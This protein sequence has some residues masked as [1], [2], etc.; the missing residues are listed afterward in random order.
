MTSGPS[1]ISNADP[2]SPPLA[3]SGPPGRPMRMSDATVRTVPDPASAVR[4]IPMTE[5]CAPPKSN[6]PT[7]SARR[8][9][10]WMVVAFVL[11]TY[12]G[13]T[14]ENH[15]A[16]GLAPSGADLSASRAASNPIV[17]VSSSYDAT[18]RVPFPPPEPTNGAIVERSSRPC[19]RY[20]PA[21]RIPRT[22]AML[23]PDLMHRQISGITRGGSTARSRRRSPGGTRR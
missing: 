9:A 8:S 10:A 5:R 13:V 15:S 4:T 7:V 16:S 14:V 11:S 23:G 12:A 2:P 20:A 3:S 18:V 17:V 22:A 19:G 21:A 1:P 6:A